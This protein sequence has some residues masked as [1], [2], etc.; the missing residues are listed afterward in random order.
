MT[1]TAS[2]LAAPGGSDTARRIPSRPVISSSSSSPSATLTYQ[3]KLTSRS[4][5]VSAPSRPGMGYTRMWL[6]FS[7]W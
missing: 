7:T 4:P 2:S 5:G 1:V 3:T 6:S